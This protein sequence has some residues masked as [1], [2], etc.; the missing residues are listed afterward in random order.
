M[1]IGL[2]SLVVVGLMIFLGWF[3]NVGLMIFSCW[4]FRWRMGILYEFLHVYLIRKYK[5]RKE[6]KILD[7]FNFLGNPKNMKNIL[8]IAL[9]KIMKIFLFS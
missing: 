2:D 4:R 7:Y 9:P 1:L 5:K 8:P 6:K 3:F